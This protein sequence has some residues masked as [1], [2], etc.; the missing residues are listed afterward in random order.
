MPT[1]PCHAH[2]QQLANKIN[3]RPLIAADRMSQTV[4]ASATQGRP[5]VPSAGCVTGS[6]VKAHDARRPAVVL[7]RRYG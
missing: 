7:E 4:S 3:Q 2:G 1:E 6:R 5:V